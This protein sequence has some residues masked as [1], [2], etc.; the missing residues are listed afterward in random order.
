MRAVDLV[1]SAVGNTFRSKTRTILTILAIF[2]GAFTLTITNGLGTGINRY[3]DDTVAAMGA[4]DVMTVTKVADNAT[5]ASDGPREYDPDA[6]VR[7]QNGPPGTTSVVAPI[8]SAELDELAGIDGV[9]RV[10]PVKSVDVD[11]IAHDGGTEYEIGVGG[12]VSG[13]RLQLAAGEQPDAAA[14]DF[15][16]VISDAYLDVLGFDDAQAAI[17]EPVTLAVTDAERT[18]HELG[19]TVVGVAEAS[20]GTTSSAVPNDALNDALFAAQSTGLDASRLDAY[21]QATVWFDPDST[22]DEVTALQDRLADAGYDSTTVAERLGAFKSV[23][24]GIVLVLNAFA[25][26]ALLAA[27]FG[28]VN[29]LLMSVQERTREIGLMK[30]MGMGSGKVFGL[31]SLEAVFIGFLGSAIGAGLGMIAGSA[32][33]SALGGA[34]LAD[35]PGLTLIAFD[36]VSIAAI[37]LVVMGVA[38]LAGTL[39]AVRAA[40]ADPVESLRYE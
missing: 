1:G 25:I 12:F 38:F 26:I 7:A 6:I 5:D 30:A 16:V 15:E 11:S 17:G 21:S 18:R 2:V 39:P 19:A 23:I 3:I 36:P 20:L 9:E 33:S 10:Q 14:S 4:D 31:F 35:L 22:A 13:M 34:L 37:I 24:D 8:G 40:R 29:T 27:S 28:I 32:I